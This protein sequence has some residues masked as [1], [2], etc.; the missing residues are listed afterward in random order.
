MKEIRFRVDEEMY[1]R[2]KRIAKREHRS[3]TQQIAHGIEKQLEEV[4]NGCGSCRDTAGE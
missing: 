1:E 2:I 3:V 4:S